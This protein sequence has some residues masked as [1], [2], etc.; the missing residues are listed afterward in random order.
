MLIC[1]LTFGIFIMMSLMLLR[2]DI[3]LRVFYLI[4]VIAFV[5]L[6]G[7]IKYVDDVADA[8]KQVDKLS[9][10]IEAGGDI[11]KHADDAGSIAKQADKVADGIDA[12]GDAARQA[13]NIGDA[14]KRVDD[15]VNFGKVECY[16]LSRVGKLTKVW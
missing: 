10:A 9:D 7:A 15:V 2:Y 6:I 5:P 4:D 13:D 1:R 14:A 8:A 16:H 12:I 11:I 3:P